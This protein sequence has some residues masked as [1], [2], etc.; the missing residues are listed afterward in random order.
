MNKTKVLHVV[1][2]MGY[3][4]VQTWIVDLTRQA[5]EENVQLD[6][7][8]YASEEWPLALLAKSYGA[9]VFV[10]TNHHNIWTLW[11]TL[12]DICRTHGPY[13]A[14]HAH[15]L[16]QNGLVLLF[17]KIL[18]VPV[19]IS[20]SHNSALGERESL[21]RRIYSASMK[22][23]LPLV[24]TRLAAVSELA[25]EKLYGA[26]WR[27]LPQSCLLYCG[28]DFSA[29]DPDKQPAPSL[30]KALGLPPEA[31]VAGHVGRFIYQ[32]NHAFLLDIMAEAMKKDQDLWLLLVGDGELKTEIA[33]KAERLG[34]SKRTIFAGIRRDIPNVLIECFDLFLMPSHFEGLPLVMLEAQG[35][36][37]KILVSDSVTREADI[38]PELVARLPLDAGVTL[39][40]NK[41]TELLKA[42]PSISHKHAYDRMQGSAF[43]IQESFR[44]SLSM[45]RK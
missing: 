43:S 14:I 2:S 28:I 20:H 4:G 25:G 32:K 17:A 36:G 10:C 29:Y 23:L 39:W 11:T 1:A 27:N 22:W 5:R 26:H 44:S 3:G 12:R 42:P 31:K 9:K 45:W 40:A 8:V 34:I 18:G 41:I 19:R 7:L 33:A 30:R 35:A 24:A 13:E 15:N 16:F 38:I 21:P 6:L 37:K